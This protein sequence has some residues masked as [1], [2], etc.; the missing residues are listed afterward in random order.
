[1]VAGL[2]DRLLQGLQ[3]LNEHF[4]ASIHQVEVDILRE[5]L[6]SKEHRI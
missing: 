6:A 1:M 4:H 2:V 5:C 3:N